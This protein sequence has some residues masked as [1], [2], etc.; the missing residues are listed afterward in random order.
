[1]KIKDKTKALFR[2]QPY[3][4]ML[5][6]SRIIVENLKRVVLYDESTTILETDFPMKICGRGLRLIYLNND[7][8]EVDGYIQSVEFNAKLPR[9]GS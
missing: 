6:N 7:N 4:Y 5:G 3:V 1:M 2:K 9:E 8:V